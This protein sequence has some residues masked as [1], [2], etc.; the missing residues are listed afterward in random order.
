V[1]WREWRRSRPSR[2]ARI[3]WGLFIVAS[4]SGTGLGIFTASDGHRGSQMFLELVGGFEAT[5]GLL[6]VSLA[7]PT[8]LAEERVRG[9]LDVLMATPL[10]TDRIVL[11]KWWGAYRVV[12]AL[13]LLPAVG[14]I[15]VA[16]G[17]PVAAAAL[18]PG[19][20]QAPPA[21]L[22]AFDRLALVALPLAALLVQGAAVTSVGLALATGIRRLGRAVAVSVT[23]YALFA[24][25]WLVLAEMEVFT[26]AL[27]WLGLISERDHET[28][29][30]LSML[31]A[32]A[33]PLGGQIITTVWINR[34]GEATRGAFYVGQMVII[35]ATLLFAL[36]VLALTMATFNRCLGR[37]PERPRPP[38]RGAGLRGPHREVEPSSPRR[39]PS[40]M[41]TSD[42][43][44]H[45]AVVLGEEVCS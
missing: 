28:E 7:A 14:A 44:R 37:M 13:A 34:P 19:P 39:S 25:G 24:F 8:V 43:T 2:L 12:P 40:G 30:F 29:F 36:L 32:G 20:G 6:L 27:S 45:E 3:V 33:C 16:T 10:P 22:G 26:G 42:P 23:S 5:F 31:L 18:R 38:R 11:S 35:L 41:I 21:P 4:L 15:V 1:L 9:S 17:D